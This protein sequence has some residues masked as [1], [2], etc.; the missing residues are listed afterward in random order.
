MSARPSVFALNNSGFDE[1]GNF[2][3]EEPIST[4]RINEPQTAKKV[5]YLTRESSVPKGPVLGWLHQ[6]WMILSVVHQ[7]ELW[8]L[9]LLCVL[10]GCCVK[11]LTKTK[12]VSHKAAKPQR[13]R[14]KEK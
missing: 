7:F 5:M 12:K 10:C 3:G 4:G 9:F 6:K 1:F 11:F 8:Y 2:D 13:T 14:R